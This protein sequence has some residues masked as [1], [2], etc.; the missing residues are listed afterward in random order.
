MRVVL[1]K[2]GVLDNGRLMYENDYIL[3]FVYPSINS[4]FSL[5]K[6]KKLNRL[7]KQSILKRQWMNDRFLN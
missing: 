6:S 1:F 3:K 7:L 2:V 4:R 5:A